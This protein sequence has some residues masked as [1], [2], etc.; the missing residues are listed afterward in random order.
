MKSHFGQLV[1]T[2]TLPFERWGGVVMRCVI[3]MGSISHD[4]GTGRGKTDVR[5]SSFLDNLNEVSSFP[6]PLPPPSGPSLVL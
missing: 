3:T 1:T 4:M 5:S 2:V 6:L